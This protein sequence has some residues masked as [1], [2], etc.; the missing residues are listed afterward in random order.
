MSTDDASGGACSAPG[1]AKSPFARVGVAGSASST[2]LPL[3]RRRKRGLARRWAEGALAAV[4]L[5][6]LV[7]DEDD[8]EEAVR[9]RRLKRPPDG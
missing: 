5:A 2:R 6:S 1:R 9:T 4:G 7:I 8:D 3:L